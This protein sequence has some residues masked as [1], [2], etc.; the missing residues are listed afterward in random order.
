MYQMKNKSVKSGAGLKNSGGGKLQSASKDQ[1][2]R[3]V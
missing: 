1:H 2:V 3:T